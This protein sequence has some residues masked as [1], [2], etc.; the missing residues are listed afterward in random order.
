[1]DFNPNETCLFCLN[2]KEYLANQ[3]ST[4]RINEYP[5]SIIDEDENAPLD[6]S[7]KSTNNTNNISI[8]NTSR[9]NIK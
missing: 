5:Q 8:S 3:K 7:L 1:M 6:L 2:R 9:T 4:H